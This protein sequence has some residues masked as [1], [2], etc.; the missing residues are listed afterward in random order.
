MCLWN[1]LLTKSSNELIELILFNILFLN[2][3]VYLKII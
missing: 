2:D 1:V 3:I